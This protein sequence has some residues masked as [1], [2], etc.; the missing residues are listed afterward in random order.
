MFSLKNLKLG[1]SLVALSCLAAQ[2]TAQQASTKKSAAASSTAKKASTSAKKASAPAEKGSPTLTLVEPLKDFGTVPRGEK[3]NV[4][5]LIKNTGTSDLEL[6]S[7]QPGCGCTVADFD[8]VIKPGKI[9]KVRAAVDTTTFTG[10]IS[11]SVTVQSNDPNTPTSQLTINALVKPYVEAFP[12]GFVRFNT[13]QG[14]VQMQSVKLYSEEETPFEIVRIVVPEAIKEFVKVTHSKLE[15]ADLV[16]AGRAGQN[17]YKL[18][19]TLGGPTAQ[20]GPLAEKIR[21][22]TNS[23]HQPE[24]PISVTGVV[25]PSISV[26]PSLVNF[27]EVAPTDPEANRAIT[28]R[29]NDLKAASA[30]QVTKAVSSAPAQF[31]TEMKATEKPG[32]FEITLKLVKNAKEGDIDGSVTI[33]TT[34]KINPVVTLPVKGTIKKATTVAAQ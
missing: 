13:V 5:F 23:K 17:Q 10:P 7:V 16:Q 28:I 33:Y 9:G 25:R 14:D 1:V 27:G 4:E 20:I 24:Y 2:A 12:A 30:F 19:I 11:K 31:T 26:S 22:V 34:D 6:L 29:S 32:E 8:K 21:V 3:L 18:D 15:G